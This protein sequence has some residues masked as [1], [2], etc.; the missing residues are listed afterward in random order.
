MKNDRRVYYGGSCWQR[1]HQALVLSFT[2]HGG[3]RMFLQLASAK[4]NKM[5][6]EGVCIPGTQNEIG[7]CW[8]PSPPLHAPV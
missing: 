1:T 8:R 7:R 2:A 6:P 3:A 4:V 5:E